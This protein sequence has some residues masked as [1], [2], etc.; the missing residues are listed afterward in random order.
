MK[1]KKRN[2]MEL[3]FTRRKRTDESGESAAS[4]AGNIIGK[5]LNF[6][7]SI[8]EKFMRLVNIVVDFAKREFNEIKSLN[9]R[10]TVIAIVVLL[11]IIA[12][13][14]LISSL[15]KNTKT[16]DIDADNHITTP[17]PTETQAISETQPVHVE[18]QDE[19]PVVYTIQARLMDL[20]YMDYDEP[21]EYYGPTT[22]SCYELFERQNG[23]EIDGVVDDEGNHDRHEHVGRP[24]LDPEDVVGDEEDREH[25]QHEGRAAHDRD[26]EPHDAREHARAR[27]AP[28]RHHDAKRHGAEQGQGEYLHR[29]GICLQQHAAD[30]HRVHVILLVR[31][32]SAAS[33]L[34]S[35]SAGP[36]G[37]S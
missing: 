18:Y 11:V 13:P 17:E 9:V 31:P 23:F 36:R 34:A 22:K 35:P 16:V 7:K 24:G 28:E 37:R 25:L 12:L 26:V 1:Q 20:G 4:K 30:R 2:L 21:T 27:E 5:I 10:H 3:V 19:G 29:D 33:R 6:F 32:R 15:S 8:P 14:I